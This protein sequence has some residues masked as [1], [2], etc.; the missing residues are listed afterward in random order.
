MNINNTLSTIKELQNIDETTVKSF[1][2]L[3]V[4]NLIVVVLLALAITVA[5]YPLLKMKILIWFVLL[6]SL[7]LYRIYCA[8]KYKK[9]P[10]KHSVM[11]W[12]Q[13]FVFSAI[14]T[15]IIY[16]SIGFIHIHM[17]E[18]YYQLFILSV[19]VGLSSGAAFALSADVR[20]SIVYLSILILPLIT[21][22]LFLVNM[23]L[24]LLLAFSVFIYYI[25]QITI[26]IYIHKQKKEVEALESQHTLL[27]TF[28]KNAPLAIFT[29]NKNL[30]I[31]DYN[32]QLSVLFDHDMDTL[33][34]MN[35]NNIPDKRPIKTL[36][37]S[38]TKGIQV[39][40]GPYVSLSGKNFEIEAKSFSFTDHNDNVRGG[41]GIIEDK[42]NEYKALE[43]LQHMVD[44]DI[45]TNLLNR[46]G[47]TNYM[48]NIILD[49]KHNEYYSILFYLDLNQFKGINDSLG[50]AVGD[51]VLVGVSRRLIRV[52]GQDCMVS[53]LGGD[54]FIIMAA[55][56]SKEKDSAMQKAEEYSNTI[57]SIFA[58]PC[59]IQDMHLHIRTSIGI[60]ILEPGYSNTEEIIRHADLTMYHAKSAT[61]HISYYNSSL[62][63]K[64]K[65]LFI[66]QQNLVYAT[67][68]GQLKLFFQPIVKMKNEVLKSA[69]VLL[70]WEHPTRG[71]LSP[72]VF[73]PLA[74][75]AGLLSKITWWLVDSVCQQI[76]KWKK[77]DKWNLE[78]ISI[79]VNS[80]QLIENHFAKEFFK[81][82]KEYKLDTDDIMLEITERSLIDD[83]ASTKGIINDL[84]S[85]GVK[86]AIDD[87]GIGY[88]SLS[89]LKKLSFH[90]LKIDR[91][92]IKDIGK[93][94]KELVLVSTILDIGRQFDYQI[95]I[96]GIE[97]EQ[98]KKELLEID[99]ELS[100]Q[101]YFFS[102]PISAEEFSKKFMLS[103]SKG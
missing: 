83:F 82:L 57:K 90:T 11:S 55:H 25:A 16:A 5:L 68:H 60:V 96:E 64:Q 75:K 87:F 42:T 32:D 29:Y 35:L 66:L 38:L 18:P 50:H 78:Y 33:I 46:R 3:S 49:P 98:Q 7:I 62:D 34:G 44:H 6:S 12:Y 56:V 21:T 8:K 39:Y 53:R 89:Y 84:R 10:T 22:L 100:Y 14:L 1:Y 92:F 43:E 41:I 61:N 88:S 9:N 54:E 26:I 28:F 63:E 27:H 102:K 73:I 65:D 40:K 94:P 67:E 103:S 72:E 95:V 77:E 86:C 30:E 31:T 51:E 37:E 52:L 23:P 15:A 79:N 36:K 70:R 59:V 4:K 91:E 97:N 47:F 24:H 85:H 48:D 2:A 74:I 45:L 80:A 69:E 19:M 20:L 99:D 17:L 13:R 76:S 71:L 81:K 93:S 101:G 58:E